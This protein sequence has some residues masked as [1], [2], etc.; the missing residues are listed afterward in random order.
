MIDHPISAVQAA[1]L[2]P[3][4]LLCTVCPRSTETTFYYPTVQSSSKVFSTIVLVKQ[5]R[6]AFPFSPAPIS[7]LF[8]F[9]IL[10]SPTIYTIILDRPN[11]S[12]IVVSFRGQ[13]LD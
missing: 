7:S 13:I 6:V 9:R 12:N 3:R 8:P 1:L 4:A 2:S 10:Y 11:L 5:A